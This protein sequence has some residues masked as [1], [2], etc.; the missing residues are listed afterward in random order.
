MSPF[1]MPVIFN[2]I[3]VGPIKYPVVKAE[4]KRSP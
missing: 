2:S 3:I 1:S 4:V